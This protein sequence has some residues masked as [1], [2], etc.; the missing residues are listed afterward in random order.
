M[1]GDGSRGILAATPGT[2]YLLPNGN[3]SALTALNGS[4]ISSGTI[5]Q[6]RFG[7][8]GDGSGSHF[9]ADDNTF[10]SIP[11]GGDMLKSD[12]LFGLAN[13][14]TARANIG[15]NSAANITTGILGAQFLPSLA[16]FTNLNGVTNIVGGSN[17]TV[18]V[19]V[20]GD[21]RKE[22]TIQG[23]STPQFL[24]FVTTLAM[25]TNNS[26]QLWTN[27]T[28]TA[29]GLL[30]AGANKQILS[31]NVG[32]GAITNDGAGT[33]GAT[34]L[35]D[36]S[37][38]GNNAFAYSDGTGHII[39]GNDG[40]SLSNIIGG[41]IV[42]AGSGISVSA[43]RITTGINAG[44]T[45]YQV[46]NTGGAGVTL[47]STNYFI[48]V[49]NAL[50]FDCSV[51]QR[52]DF[53]VLTNTTLIISNAWNLTNT[54][55]QTFQINYHEDTNGTWNLKTILVSGGLLVTNN[56]SY[57]DTNKNAQTRL[58]GRL[59]WSRT[60]VEIEIVTNWLPQYAFTN[61]NQGSGG[62][63]GGGSPLIS[64]RPS[65]PLL[66]VVD[67]G[68][69]GT[70]AADASGNGL[71]GTFH[72][73]PSWAA[74]YIGVASVQFHGTSDGI[75]ST[76]SSLL[77]ATANDESIVLWFKTSTSGSLMVIGGVA[78]TGTSKVHL[79]ELGSSGQIVAT[80]QGSGGG[81][82]S[83][84]DSAQNFADGSWHHVVSILDHTAKKVTLW[85]DGSDIG[86]DTGATSGTLDFG[87]VFCVGQYGASG[88]F[89]FTGFIDEP[90]V[91]PFALSSGQ[92]ASLFGQTHP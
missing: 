6:A 25:M 57:F 26:A 5:N 70:T 78:N 43:T 8:G 58:I 80:C 88:G 48:S 4:A 90:S 45:N 39:S 47:G 87:G 49:T 12:N 31:A 1:K 42:S 54:S 16:L 34:P 68:T 69:S 27:A 24:S 11:G 13:N 61:S 76:T 32:A 22:F 23:I 75:A 55:S 19:T 74:P 92:I 33:W 83:E 56:S 53:G 28:F 30:Y 15:A 64:K 50:V 51:N 29:N 66:E 14:T 65:A 89:G 36:S 46:I 2:D 37:G 20:F 40:S 18:S 63:G 84:T 85:V 44:S 21:G 81:P 7:T 60:N 79:I 91:Y 10:K 9:F 52:G 62:G 41:T 38:L 82:S 77:D 67:E 17:V 86:T 71:T 35:R 72:G 3:G 73:S 59:D